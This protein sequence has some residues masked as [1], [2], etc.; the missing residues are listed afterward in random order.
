[1]TP[2]TTFVLRFGWGGSP[3]IEHKRV[4]S[5][6][7]PFVCGFGRTGSPESQRKRGWGEA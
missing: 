5:G 4:W 2:N 6:D 1:M 3:E 7:S